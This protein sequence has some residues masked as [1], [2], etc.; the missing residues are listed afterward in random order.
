[1]AHRHLFRPLSLTLA[2]TL[3][4]TPAAS[5]LTTDQARELLTD[6]YIDEIPQSVL[7]QETVQQI[8]EALGDPYTQYF[9][10]EEYAQFNSSM[11]DTGLVGIGIAM[12]T[13]QEGLLVQRVY[14]D[15]PA[16]EGGLQTGDL[17][18]AVDGKAI[19]GDNLLVAASWLQGEEGTQ[20]EVTYLRDGTE[21]TVTLT[22]RA[23][24]LPATY[25]ELVD[26]HIG[27]ID[28]DTFGGHT[29]EHFLDGL[30]TYASQADQWLVDLQDN[31]GGM[32]NAAAATSSC[33]TGDEMTGYYRDKSGRITPFGS[34]QEQQT[35]QPVIVLT[36]ENTASASELFAAAIRDHDAGLVVGGRTYGKGVAQNVFNQA[37]LPDYFPDGDALKITTYRLFSPIG[38]TTNTIGVFPHLLVDSAIAPEVALLLSSACPDQDT[39]NTLRI[40]FAQTWY[41]DLDAAL[42]QD[43]R[44]A[45]T[46]LLEALPETVPVLEGTGG[47]DGWTNTTAAA[48]AEKYGLTDYTPRTFSDIAGS[49]YCQAIQLLATYGV[50]Q[51]DGSGAF[52]PTEG[53]TRAQLCALLAQ[54]LHCKSYTGANQFSD[55]P[56]DS[57]Y[58]SAV[59]TMARMGLV[60]GVGDGRF[61]PDAPVDHQQF[62]TMM[63][64]LGRQLNLALDL[65]ASSQPAD[66]AEAPELAEYAGWAR[67]SV[68]LLGESASLLWDEP[69]NIDPTAPATREEAAALTSSLL[70]HTG[71]LPV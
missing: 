66:A 20:V 29:L 6:Y 27:Y 22:R 4:L 15:T 8:V 19:T 42:S 47:A 61:D 32:V 39:G 51:G 41:V 23:V 24:V 64:R 68:W 43:H 40:D 58:A 59:N 13:V 54:A 45:F 70:V 65:T 25:T 34:D 60:E 62:I 17:I 33:F 52:R 7:D 69:E 18:V 48:L 26:G 35:T 16:A 12:L 63:A 31:G 28:C 14:Q 10:A 38:S 1:M 21:H 67:D 2:L 11:E 50:L 57:W 55:V 71:L 49:P 44:P 53:L 46:A 3:A 36:N 9:T 5:A 37:V 30:E 56:E